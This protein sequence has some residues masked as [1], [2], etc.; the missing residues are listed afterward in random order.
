MTDNYTDF[1]TI[2]DL[3]LKWAAWKISVDANTK[4][5][6]AVNDFFNK[7]LPCLE[8]KQFQLHDSEAGIIIPAIIEKEFGHNTARF[9]TD[10]RAIVV[11]FATV[12]PASKICAFL[13]A[14][15]K[16]NN[17]KVTADCL[18]EVGDM[19]T[20]EGLQVFDPVTV[21][22][23][24][25]K[26]VGSSTDQGI[27]K[28]ALH[29]IGELYKIVNEDVYKY[30]QTK[31]A[32]L[33]QKSLDMI[34][35]RL[36]MIRKQDGGDSKTAPAKVG[37]A[38]SKMEVKTGA[39]R[40][41]PATTAAGR[42]SPSARATTTASRSP[43]PGARTGAAASSATSKPTASAAPMSIDDL[44]D[45]FRLDLDELGLG[46][47]KLGVGDHDLLNLGGYS[48]PASIPSKAVVQRCGI[49]ENLL[50]KLNP[51][52]SEDERIEAMGTIW[53]Q[54]TKNGNGIVKPEAD[55]ITQLLIGQV[56]DGF[57]K[58]E[59]EEIS[60]RLCKYAV[61]LLRE[62]WSEPTVPATV[63]L[64]TLD[65]LQRMLIMRLMDPRT[66]TKDGG[67]KDKGHALYNNLSTLEIAI[68]DMSDRTS[69]FHIL[70]KLLNLEV[71]NPNAP[72][73]FVDMTTRCLV[74]LLKKLTEP[75]PPLNLPLLLTNCHDFF[76]HH[77]ASSFTPGT[78]HCEMPLTI[79]L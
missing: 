76:E 65:K 15:F 71:A 7:L 12:Y 49:D 1:E 23:V 46:S 29:C 55:R 58:A 75:G 78:E 18:E 62:M 4:V 5:V 70:L 43:G 54:M 66:Q 39:V 10:S 45:M 47:E 19:L 6:A 36:R 16:S 56:N 77:P 68:I 44:P 69:S 73:G 21:M 57:D 26:L 64:T 32:P 33:D 35:E 74:K 67:D 61:Q 53:A 14:G 42:S 28:G 52:I 37:A 25:G 63:H 40:S 60:Y 3:V 79:L 8:E 30:V 31:K 72:P 9:R 2:L 50:L 27:R 17:K 11:R 34:A 22:P 13:V 48:A 59:G 20:R 41:T 38:S 51:S 24:V